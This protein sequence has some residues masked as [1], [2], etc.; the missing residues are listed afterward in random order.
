MGLY[1]YECA[2]GCGLISHKTIKS[3]RNELIRE[4]GIGLIVYEFRKA[5]NADINWVKDV[6]G[7]IPEDWK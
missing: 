6:G 2:L 7:Y 3:A 4:N 5:T 1:Y